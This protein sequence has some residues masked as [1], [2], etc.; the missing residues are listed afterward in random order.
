M[1]G[2][3]KLNGGLAVMGYRAVFQWPPP[4]F[5][6]RRSQGS[7]GGISMEAIRSMPDFLIPDKEAFT[8]REVARL[9]KVAHTTIFKA[10]AE[11]RIQT[12]SVTSGALGDRTRDMIPRSE[13]ERL[14]RQKG[15]LRKEKQ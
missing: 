6:H 7:T 5:T 14:A 12:I 1:C 3:G 9:L 4:A 13:V 15:L 10:V 2:G 8:Y 11:G